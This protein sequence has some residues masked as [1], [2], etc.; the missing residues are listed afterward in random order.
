MKVSI[1]VPAY[2]EE[3]RILNALN[4]V[5]KRNDVEVVIVDDGSTD[6]TLGVANKF[7]EEHPDQNIRIIHLEENKGLGNAK[8]V[9][10]DNAIG[11]YIHQLD[12]D[13]YLYTEEY[14]KVL[15]MLDGTDMV[16]MNLRKNDGTVFDITA[17]SQRCL[18]AG[19]ARFIKRSFLGDT[20]CPV[21]DAGEDWGLNEQ[22]QAKPH[23]DKFTRIVGYHYNF[24]REG[25]LFDR[26]VKGQLKPRK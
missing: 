16:Y 17:E 26:L 13:D 5:P 7:K 24:P 8:N 6:N 21:V 11:E 14:N 23:T 1:I 3:T 19:T 4:S 10:Y 18:C 12:C 22:L 2:N 15:D 25:S 20:R 9:G